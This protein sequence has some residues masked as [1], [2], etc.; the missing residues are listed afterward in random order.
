M[1][2]DHGLRHDRQGRFGPPGRLPE[3][4]VNGSLARADSP[5]LVD[6]DPNGAY[7]AASPERSHQ[8]SWCETA[9]H[10]H[11]VDVEV[12][13]I[14][15]AGLLQDVMA[16]CAE[17]KT[18]ASSVTARVKR[19]KT[20]VISLTLEIANLVHLHKVLEKLRAIKDVRTVY[21]VTKREAKSG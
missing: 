21:R 14:D 19:D 8:A 6:Q 17:Y 4:G 7:M 2:P 5:S 10:T 18:N 16:A 3:R 1:G 9:E 13:A 15:R 20:A 11:A 12:E